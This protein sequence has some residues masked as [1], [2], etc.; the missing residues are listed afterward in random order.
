MPTLNWIGKDAVINH[1]HEVKFR[2]LKDVPE[3]GCGD[4]GTGNLIVEGDNLEA[5]KAL[6]PYYAGQ[7]KCI[8]IDPPYNTGNEGWVYNDNVKSPII[9]EWLGKVVGKEGETLDRHDRWLC[10]MYPRLALL[11]EFLREDGSIFISL[12][13][14]EIQALRYVM[15]EIFGESNFITSICWH[16]RV[17]PANDAHFFSTDHDWIVVYSRNSKIWRPNRLALTEEQE[18]NYSNT[19]DDTRGDWNS[20]AYTCAKN[21]DERPN[22]YYAL[23]QPNTG[24]EI[25]PSKFRVWAYDKIT[26][27]QHIQEKRIYWGKEGL[28]TKPRLKKFLS[29]A[30]RV[31]PR[32]IWGFK[33]A[34]H[35][36]EAK[37]EILDVISSVGFATPK[38]TRLI[39]RILQIATNPGDLVLDS[40]A[41]SG[42]TGHAVLKM[43]AAN[44]EQNPR[45]FIL[46][47]MEPAIAKTITAER[48]KRVA[49]GYTNA[50]GE[51]VPGLG[52]GFRY[53]QL[54]EPLFDEAGQIRLTV[55]FSELARHVWFTE[56]GE[57]HEEMMKDEGGRMKVWKPS[58]L[59]GVHR[60][61]A[62][63][64]LYNGILGDKSTQGGNVL[65]RAILAEL[66]VFEGPKVIYAEACLLGPDRL[67]ACQITVRQ[68][69]KQIRVA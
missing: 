33:E 23:K 62:I 60:G 64:L 45:R 15:D 26:H 53:C 68:T 22:L 21:A 46:V 14:N 20:S 69:P 47:E 13:D 8:Y 35:N 43:N 1:H 38:P 24:E 67:R 32:S 9:T 55:K 28:S 36:Q 19:D 10:M 37:L 31:V 17:S 3:L 56:T 16:K 59:L 61:T 5:L 48:V 7:V 57:P 30:K 49:E 18:G 66:P 54:G 12:D 34:G 58:P 42:T 11:K 27:A 52:G 39:E 2:L 40:F 6:L 4:P 50:K 41:G 51:A 44:P 63:Y 25:W 29:D 65:T